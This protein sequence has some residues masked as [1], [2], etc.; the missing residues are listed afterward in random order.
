MLTVVGALLVL[1]IGF[2]GGYIVRSYGTFN[3]WISPTSQPADTT[4]ASPSALANRVRE[5][6]SDL[7]DEA[8]EP[9]DMDTATEATIEALL[10][11]TGDTHA[12]YYTS[13]EYAQ[14][15]KTDNGDY[16][17]IGVVLTDYRGKAMVTRVYPNTPASDAG[18]HVGD[19]ITGV[20][21]DVRDG[22]TAAEIVKTVQG[23][24]GTS[25]II[26][27]RRP[28]S[29]EDAGGEVM[30]ATLSLS[31]VKIP[32]VESALVDDVGYIVLSKFTKDSTE[33]MRT[34]LE[35]L[36]AQGARGYVIDLRNDTGGYLTQCIQITSLFQSSGTV[37]QIQT[38]TDGLTKEQVSGK[39]VT[40][41]PL[42]I[43]VNGYSASASEIMASSLHDSG[44]A[45]LVGTKTYGKGSVQ[46]IRELSFGGAIKYTIAHYLTAGG[47][48]I[49]GVGITPDI[50]IDMDSSLLATGE[51]DTQYQAALQNCREKIVAASAADATE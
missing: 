36:E 46:S 48:D 8:Y 38:R 35:G 40:D 17:G 51:T 50:V 2:A 15:Q 14:D 10:K 9:A 18:I 27:W 29:P 13:D 24:V 42:T 33:D 28:A 34:A 6:Q 26:T 44:R 22:W 23:S 20:G 37:V 4:A 43:L 39:T 25:F 12:K 19:F 21:E 1:L 31:N 16:N 3:R 7:Y 47:S 32:N 49:D 30:S 11:S 5:V 41:K 45:T